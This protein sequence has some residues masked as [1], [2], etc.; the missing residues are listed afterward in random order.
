MRRGVI[1][2]L[3]GLAGLVGGVA[4]VLPGLVAHGL[5]ARTAARS[6]RPS[7]QPPAPAASSAASP[8]TAPRF[9]GRDPVVAP[10]AALDL[11]PRFPFGLRPVSFFEPDR[12]TPRWALTSRLDGV[13]DILQFWA[14]P[15]QVAAAVSADGRVVF[16]Q[17]WTTPVTVAALSG[18]RAYLRVDRPGVPTWVTLNLITGNATTTSTP[19]VQVTGTLTLEGL[20]SAPPAPTIQ[21]APAAPAPASPSAPTLL[22]VANRLLN[23]AVPADAVRVSRTA[24]TATVTRQAPGRW[25]AVVF[26]REG[27]AWVPTAVT[28]TV[29]QLSL[30]YHVA[31]ADAP[32][33]FSAAAGDA[34][35]VVLSA[36]EMN[37]L[38][39]RVAAEPYSLWDTQ[40]GALAA[41][42]IN[43]FGFQGQDP[44]QA[45]IVLDGP[46]QQVLALTYQ[47]PVGRHTAFLPI[48]WY[49]WR[50]GPAVVEPPPTPACVAPPPAGDQSLG[51]Q[52]QRAACLDALTPWIRLATPTQG[53]RLAPGEHLAVRGTVTDA[54]FR[55]VPVQWTLLAGSEKPSAV[56]AQGVAAVAADGTVSLDIAV[57]AEWPLLHG[58]ALTLMLQPGVRQGPIAEILL[59]P[60]DGSP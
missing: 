12:F 43:L 34:F 28:A 25:T 13:P 57:P 22:A 36:R 8:P 2:S 9:A 17:A 54:V 6:P 55:G 47:T 56:I 37:V 50:G 46:Q 30:T 20:P 1:G 48:G 60:A 26:A 32:N 4:A 39:H 53:Q 5:G 52:I 51:A 24:S 59:V 11:P 18:D 15:G 33:T 10:R 27:S 3:V 42:P 58:P 29:D 16:A 14:G 38:A 45:K 7:T 41:L 49:W 40:A 44:G 35:S 19:P 21:P 31:V 23:T